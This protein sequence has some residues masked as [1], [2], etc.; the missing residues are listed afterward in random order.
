LRSSA[1][2][3]N[4]ATTVQGT[5]LAIISNPHVYHTLQDE[6][7]IALSRNHI[8]FPIDYRQAKELPYLQACIKEGLR[9][10]QPLFQLRE[11]V[12]PPEGD[13]V[14]GYYVPGGTF[15]GLN[16]MATQLNSVFGDDPESFRPERWFQYD[17]VRTKK[18]LQTLD[19]V[20]ASGPS[21][22]MGA[23]IALMEK[24]KVIFEVRIMNLLKSLS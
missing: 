2:A 3:E 21:R 7:D 14:Q 1:G 10:F 9:L 20:F 22:C 8:G 11:R 24:S 12:V 6:V 19:L 23:N 4:L 5:T 18:M 15:I 13:F 17:D 16:A